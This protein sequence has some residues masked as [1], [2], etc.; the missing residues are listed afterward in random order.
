MQ[1]YPLFLDISEKN[2]LVVGAG[3]VGRR[4]IAGL[5]EAKAAKIVVID[6]YL[7]YSEFKDLFFNE[8]NKIPH[9]DFYTRDFCESDLDEISLAF[10]ATSENE[11]NGIIANLCKAKKIWCNVIENVKRGDFIVP[12]HIQCSEIILAL[13]TS[14]LSPALSKALKNDL[15]LWLDNSYAPFLK[16]LEQVRNITLSYIENSEERAKI[17][18]K[19]V[20]NEIR[21]ELFS[22]L[23][24]KKEA[25]FIQLIYENIPQ[26]IFAKIVWEEVF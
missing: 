12:A 10:A 4:K 23:K 6:K 16:L 8:Y 1:Y 26:T 17:F 18:R 20:Q 25:E 15:S 24:M 5:Q 22:L 21:Q 3:K 9:V 11:Q 14:G 13:S 7:L 2:C 19:L